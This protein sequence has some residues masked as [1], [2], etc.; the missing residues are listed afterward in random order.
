MGVQM[1]ERIEWKEEEWWWQSIAV[2][3]KVAQVWIS[4]FLL[5]FL[6]DGING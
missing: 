3:V 2:A 1:G 4:F 6:I 5:I